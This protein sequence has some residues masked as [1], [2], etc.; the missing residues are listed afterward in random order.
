MRITPKLESSECVRKINSSQ[1]GAS[2]NLELMQLCSRCEDV[3]SMWN[4]PRQIQT[5]WHVYLYSWTLRSTSF[6][7]LTY[8]L[9][10]CSLVI[11][12]IFSF[13]PRPLPHLP[14][15]LALIISADSWASTSFWTFA[16]ERRG[17][18]V[19]RG[20]IKENT[21]KTDGRR[22]IDVSIKSFGNPIWNGSLNHHTIRFL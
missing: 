18:R 19:I 9:F 12:H 11:D 2:K 13:H 17:W 10:I 8:N 1:V 5:D 7:L 14:N 3:F 16:A 21:M 22:W 6:N 20:N 4:T 15:F